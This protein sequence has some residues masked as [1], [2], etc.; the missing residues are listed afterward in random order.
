MET[1]ATFNRH[2]KKDLLLI[3][4]SVLGAIAISKSGLL[5]DVL[6][7]SVEVEFLGAFVAGIL[8]TS[9]FTTP[10]AA[11]IF[12]ALAPEMSTPVLVIVGASGAL[13]GDLFLF[14]LIRHTFAADVE[15]L[16][17]SRSHRRYFAL[18]HRRMFRWIIPFVG[19][20]IIASPLPDEL[21]IALMG[22]S[23]MKISTL[24]T[25]S[26]VMNALGIALVSLAA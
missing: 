23:D 21:G 9:L 2:L 4:V 10:L 17:R 16:L 22:V 6:Q 3:L 1:R 13:L 20:I 7:V 14:G 18:F 5:A 26:F 24:A 12:L 25:I 11:A 15:Y 8:F 19:A